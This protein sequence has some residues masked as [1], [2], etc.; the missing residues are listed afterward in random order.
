MTIMNILVMTMTTVCNKVNNLL[1][2]VFFLLIFLF[3]VCD[4]PVEYV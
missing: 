2:V 3:M 1:R 4:V